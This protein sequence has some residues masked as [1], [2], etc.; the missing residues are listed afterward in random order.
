MKVKHI[1]EDKNST[2][3]EY[4]NNTRPVDY[5]LRMLS[6]EVN[7]ILN[8]YVMGWNYVVCDSHVHF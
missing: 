1:K 6:S 3:S 2:G 7:L 5:T 8:V 4:T